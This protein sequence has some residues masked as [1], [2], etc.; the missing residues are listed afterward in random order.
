M[1]YLWLIPVLLIAGQA[2]ASESVVQ[3]LTEKYQQ[4]G[5]VNVDGARGKEMWQQQHMQKKLGKMV[6]CVSCH[7]ADLRQSGEHLRTGKYIEAMAPSVNR[8]RLND[9]K[10]IEKWFLRNC[11]WTWGRECTIQEKSDILA[12]LQAL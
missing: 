3:A 5:A 4:A 11:K 7:G 10:K 1:K 2:Q 6:S 8:E 9:P 12:F